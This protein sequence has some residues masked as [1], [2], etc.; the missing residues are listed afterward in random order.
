MISFARVLSA[1]SKVFLSSSSRL[2]GLFRKTSVGD[3]SAEDMRGKWVGG[4]CPG[5][6]LHVKMCWNTCA[7]SQKTRTAYGDEGRSVPCAFKSETD[8]GAEI[9][10]RAIIEVSP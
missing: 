7:G 3:L 4:R 2:S 10:R 6:R 5:A 1:F 9:Q 8:P